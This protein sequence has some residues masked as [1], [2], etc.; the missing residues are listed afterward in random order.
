MMMKTEEI[1]DGLGGRFADAL[2]AALCGHAEVAA[3][4]GDDEAGEERLGETLDDVA[5][6]ERTV[7]VVKVG[8]GVESQQCDA[9]QGAA[10]DADSVGDD[11]EEEEH[12]D[13]GVEARG[14]ELADGVGSEGAH[15]VDL[16]GDLHGADLGG[17]TGGVAAGDHEAGEHRAE[18]LDHGER[19]KVAGQADGAERLERGGRLQGENAAGKEAGQDDDGHGAD[20][21]GVHLGVDVGPIAGAG[22]EIRDRAPGQDGV[23]LDGGNRLLG[24]DLW[25]DKGHVVLWLR[26]SDAGTQAGDCIFLK[27]CEVSDRCIEPARNEKIEGMRAEMTA[28]V[29]Y[30]KEDLRL[31]RVAMPQAGAGELVVRVGAA[32]TCGTDLKV[33]RRGYHAMMLKPPIAVWA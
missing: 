8:G 17:H 24:E 10:G 1:D 18:L 4:G 27:D 16:L 25:R 2:G 14:D 26:L 11:G 6:L 19:D 22:E 21:D 12:E 3:D 13:G 31:E 15:G 30:G 23:V 33:Y 7:G 28:A 20:A 32:L 5:V 29:L 9:D